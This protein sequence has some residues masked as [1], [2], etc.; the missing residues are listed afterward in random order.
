MILGYFI[1]DKLEELKNKF[2][3]FELCTIIEEDRNTIYPCEKCKCPVS[4]FIEYILEKY[5]WYEN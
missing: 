4:E 5:N 2:C 3:T 1:K